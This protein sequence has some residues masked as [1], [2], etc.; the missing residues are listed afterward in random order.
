MKISAANSRATKL[1][2]TDWG[3]PYMAL[4][5]TDCDPKFNALKPVEH[6]MHMVRDIVKF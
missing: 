1:S 5:D 3:T 2:Q 4:P 6:V